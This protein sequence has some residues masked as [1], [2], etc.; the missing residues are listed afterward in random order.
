MK[1][2]KGYE[3]KKVSDKFIVVPSLEESVN[4][5][6][7]I[8]LNVTGKLLFEALQTK[9]HSIDS[10]TKLLLDV[11]EIDVHTARKDVKAFIKVLETNN[12][13]EK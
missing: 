2:K 6:G 10:L 12:L 9:K 5:S 11:Y 4:F 1:I 13:V 3:I 7:I 8:T